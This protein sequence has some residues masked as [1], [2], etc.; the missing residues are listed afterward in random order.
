MATVEDRV[1]A[2]GAA[3]EDSTDP[4]RRRWVRWLLITVCL[5]IAAMWV[6]A[7]LFAPSKG[8][9]RVDDANWRTRAEQI[10][11]AANAERVQL[12]DTSGGY[13]ANPT[14][15]QMRQRATV[16][17]QATDILERMLDDVVAVPVPTDRD[18]LLIA[19]FE[20]YY[21]VIIADR[22]TYTAALNEGRL[23]S[24]EET[25]VDG[26]PVTNVVTDFTSGN[27]V[28]AC[29]PPGELGSTL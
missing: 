20:K 15:A 4:P 21:R 5:G 17:N 29:V 2:T 14:P 3:G 22:R 7:F 10:C 24:Y 25:S 18:R 19:T 1:G 28:K 8:V 6:Y 13:I 16:V 11:T 27:D 9:Y 26:G 23:V 12:A